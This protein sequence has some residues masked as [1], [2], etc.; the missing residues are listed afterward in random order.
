MKTTAKQT[1]AVYLS[2]QGKSSS[3]IARKLY[4][5]VGKVEEWLSQRDDIISRDKERLASS[6]LNGLKMRGY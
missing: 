4:V 2:S 5:T 3:Y 1:V 6:L